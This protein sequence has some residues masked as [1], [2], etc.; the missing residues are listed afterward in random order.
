M[1]GECGKDHAS[2][3]ILV[4]LCVDRM[5]FYVFAV[6]STIGF[7]GSRCLVPTWR[8]G[9]GTSFIFSGHSCL[10]PGFGFSVLWDSSNSG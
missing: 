2:V 5:S 7:A 8:R 1:G 4:I 9:E 10:S 3:Q 6:F